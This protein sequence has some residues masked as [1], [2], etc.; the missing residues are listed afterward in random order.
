MN[1]RRVSS[2]WQQAAHQDF[3]VD[4]AFAIAGHISDFKT[5][6]VDLQACKCGEP[7]C[8]PFPLPWSG[9]V[10]AGPFSKIME[11]GLRHSCAR[12]VIDAFFRYAFSVL[13]VE[14]RAI[15]TNNRGRTSSCIKPLSLWPSFRCRLPAVCKTPHRA[16]WQALRR[17]RLLPILPTTAPSPA[18]LSADW[19]V[20]RPAASTSACRPAIDLILAQPA[21]VSAIWAKATLWRSTGNIARLA[22]FAYLAP[23]LVHHRSF[24][25]V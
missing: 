22:A 7:Y 21:E 18:R 25:H 24:P 11:G 15:T 12:Y 8:Y 2:V 19:P 23:D 20:R 4:I 3:S 13:A 16:V 5:A 10:W 1:P 6:F 9:P 14:S 17:V